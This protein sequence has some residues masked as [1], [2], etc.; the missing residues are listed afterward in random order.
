MNNFKAVL[1][2]GWPYLRR[3]RGRL[4]AGILFGILFGIANGGFVWAAKTLVE[5]LDPEKPPAIE[6]ADKPAS[7]TFAVFKERLVELKQRV[8]KWID[9][10]LPIAGGIFTW[11]RVLGALLFLPI[12]ALILSSTDYLADYCMG[13][14]SERVINDLRVDVLTKLNTLSLDYFNRS[15]TG[16]L[17]TRIHVD[18]MNLHKALKD[19]C[20]DLVKATF[21]FLGV[22]VGLCIIDWKLTLFALIFLPI[23]LFPV[24][25]LGRKA[26]RASRS[27][28]KASVS[29]SSL[30]VELITGIRV[31]KAFNLEQHELA[32]F[33][34]HSK[35]LVHHGMKNVQAKG[36]TNPLIHLISMFGIGILIIYIF[37]TRQT[38]ADMTGFLTALAVL[39][40][41]VKRI[42]GVHINVSQAG[43]GIERLIETLSE[44]PTVRE[45]VPA[46]PVKTFQS[47]IS[48]ENVSFSYGN[49]PVLRDI[50]L[51]IP[52]GFK[53]GVAGESGSGKS[54]LV[55]LLFRFYDPTNGEIKIDSMD[56]REVSVT[57]LRQQ[58]ALVSQEIV[59]FNKSVAENIEN[60]K[61]GASRAEIETAAQDAFAHEF[62]SQLPHG[63]DTVIGER[64]VTLSGGQR[65]RIAIARA[66]IRNAPI[67]VL[68]EATASLDSQSEAEVQAA[69]E[70]L[71]QNRTVVCVAH[72]L[73]TLA[74]M[75]S[76][77]VVSA[78]KIVEQGSF[79]ELLK[80]NGLFA[81]MAR[82][83]GIH[84]S[85]GL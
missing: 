40:G 83:Q 48:L 32:R 5:R 38:V 75:D 11:Q 73:S 67:L 41:A 12:L 80:A 64:G 70:K 56:L 61:L 28:R 8:E 62:I 51:K 58:M 10:W 37:Y 2:F 78:G 68:D 43:A 7:K 47:Q 3:Y 26:R 53:L 25:V 15:A 46:K 52:R 19:C 76:V 54:T 59:L 16:D 77:V 35:Q 13:W 30:L 22:I 55:N 57:D 31:V 69:I 9:P 42:A 84:P 74:T 29:Q 45:P 36:L 33:K 66:F 44:Q 6:K 81:A 85:S 14:V 60:G 23:C 79:S 65:Q 63:Y 17:I 1:T 49:Q 4:L 21:Q 18:T 34:E 50:N 71:E 27:T 72:R 20:S 82:R 24:L 39:F